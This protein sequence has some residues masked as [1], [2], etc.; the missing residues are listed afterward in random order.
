MALNYAHSAISADTEKIAEQIVDAAFQVHKY[1]GPGLTERIYEE[2]IVRELQDRQLAFER[3]KPIHVR[4]KHHDLGIDYRLDLYVENAVVI[5]L[6]CAE[7]ISEQHRAQIMCYMKLVQSRLGL[8]INFNAPTLKQG[9][10]R[11]A[12]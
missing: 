1:F 9:I 12:L 5:E 4:Y 6:K 11:I 2:A 8:I 10:K 7:N 3:Q